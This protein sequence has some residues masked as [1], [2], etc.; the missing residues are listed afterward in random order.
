MVAYTVLDAKVPVL[1]CTWRLRE[2]EWSDQKIQPASVVLHGVPLQQ[3]AVFWRTH[4]LRL[5]DF[6]VRPQGNVIVNPGLTAG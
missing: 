1:Y 5:C 4:G 3:S 2:S 6:H